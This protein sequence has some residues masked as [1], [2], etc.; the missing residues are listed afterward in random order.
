MELVWFKF[1]IRCVFGSSTGPWCRQ[2]VLFHNHHTLYV[3]PG[4]TCSVL[5]PLAC[6]C[7]CV[8]VCSEQQSMNCERLALLCPHGDQMVLPG[9][10]H[11]GDPGAAGGNDLRELTSIKHTGAHARTHT[12]TY[13]HYIHADVCI[14]IPVGTLMDIISQPLSLTWT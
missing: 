3:K 12:Q 9:D 7:L 4:V 2:V 10:H 6:V 8:G 1:Y 5:Y 14:A 11:Q 13:I